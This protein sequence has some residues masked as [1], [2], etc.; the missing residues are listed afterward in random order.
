[1]RLIFTLSLLLIFSFLSKGQDSLRFTNSNLFLELGGAAFFS[2]NIERLIPISI[3]LDLIGRTG[4]G[5][6]PSELGVG[7]QGSTFSGLVPLLIGFAYGG[8]LAFEAG[9]GITLGWGSEED[10]Y[11]NSGILKWYN[12]TLGLRYQKPGRPFLFR[13]GYTP[14]LK[15]RNICLDT[16]CLATRRESNFLHF[17]GIS[18]GSRIKAKS[19][20]K[21][22]EN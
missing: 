3:H 18:F 17:F 21:R 15:Y 4:L 13:A 20:S 22:T 10:A 6:Y 14:W 8:S 5:V 7:A 12:G 2:G 1:M 16:N 11:G 19:L 9:A